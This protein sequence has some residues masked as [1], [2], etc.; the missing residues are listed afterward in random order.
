VLFVTDVFEVAA[1]AQ[2]RQAGMPD[3]PIVVIPHR[4]GWQS[5]DEVRTGAERSLPELLERLTEG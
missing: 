3:L 5:E 4:V 2:A 1:K